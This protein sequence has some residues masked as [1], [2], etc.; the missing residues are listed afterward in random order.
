MENKKVV[1]TGIGI[2]T[3]IGNDYSDIMDLLDNPD[4]NIATE[5]PD[6]YMAVSKVFGKNDCRRMDEFALYSLM[7]GYNAISDAKLILDD[8]DKSRMGT[9]YTTSWGTADTT[10]KYFAP[11]LKDGTKGVSPLLFPY[12]VTNA[13]LGA[14]A[15]F[16]G[17]SGV[18]TMLTDSFSLDFAYR[19]ILDNK[20][21][22]V[23]CG[24]TECLKK[25]IEKMEL[26]QKMRLPFD[27]SVAMVLETEEHAHLRGARIY[28]E[29][30]AGGIRFSKN[31][32]ETAALF[33]DSTTKLMEKTGINKNYQIVFSDVDVIEIKQFR[34]ANIKLRDCLCRELP[35]NKQYNLLSMQQMLSVGYIIKYGDINNYNILNSRIGN[36]NL[37]TIL[38]V[39]DDE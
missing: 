13:A 24:A 3:S 16:F 4:A 31:V 37:N 20:A 7:A 9:V 29:L 17:F 10:Y 21:D 18:S 19:Q 14:V 28:A 2:S 6:I 26:E 38:V 22:V 27:G 5:G 34:E 33:A 23:L 12:T 8:A 36:G 1:I 25:L 35:F 15:R 32:Q 11:V 30:S 39:N